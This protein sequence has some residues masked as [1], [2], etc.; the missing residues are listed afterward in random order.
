M[1][2]RYKYP[3]YNPV[4][5]RAILPDLQEALTGYLG[6]RG[7][8]F[9]ILVRVLLRANKKKKKGMLI[10]PQFLEHPQSRAPVARLGTR[11]ILTVVSGFRSGVR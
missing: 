5:I 1:F 3:L 6:A 8:E 4:L 11:R 2:L 10:T 9:A 7:V